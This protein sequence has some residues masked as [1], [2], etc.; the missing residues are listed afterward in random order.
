MERVGIVG[1]GLIDRAWTVIFARAG[2]PVRLWDSAESVAVSTMPLCAAGLGDPAA[3]G[4]CDDREDATAGIGRARAVFVAFAQVPVI[5]LKQIEGFVLNRLQGAQ[6]ARMRR[7]N[8][9]LAVPCAHK[10]PT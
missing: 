6:L 8:R 5:V 2:W 9:R 1:A 3:N 4:V 10:F 7:R